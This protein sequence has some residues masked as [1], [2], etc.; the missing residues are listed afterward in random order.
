M[1]KLHHGQA[2]II[3]TDIKIEPFAQSNVMAIARMQKA[4]E[5]LG[6]TTDK[7][8]ETMYVCAAE[9]VNQL[10]ETFPET[11]VGKAF[12][13]VYGVPRGGWGIAMLLESSKLA[14]TVDTP[15]QADIIVDDVIDSGDT[16][17]NY[18]AMYPDKQFYAPYVNINKWIV[19]PW[20]KSKEDDAQELIT[21]T[22]QHIGDN[23]KRE[24]LLETPQRVVKSWAELYAGYKQDPYKLLKTFQS[25]SNQIVVCKDVEFYSTCEHHMIPFF[26]KMHV[27]YI[28]SG[29]V[30]G[31]SKIARVIDVFARRLQIQEQLTQEVMECIN[32]IGT[33]G[34]MVVAEAKHLCMCGRGVGKQHSSMTTSAICG[35]FEETSA[36]NEFLSLVQ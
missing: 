18:E 30:L 9:I 19:F 6:I 36:R 35:A 23:P 22:I 12:P 34:V 14:C 25:T 4:M 13:K 7:P 2:H 28:P 1:M 10:Y 31:L 11:E 32:S 33:K 29:R 21:R 27:G 3:N 17:H 15:E 24:G 16:K 20:E 8:K 5:G 26:G